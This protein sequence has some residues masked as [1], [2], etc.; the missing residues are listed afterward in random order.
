MSHYGMPGMAMQFPAGQG[1][2]PPVPFEIPK[3]LFRYGEQALWS[4]YMV[5]GAAGTASAIANAS[6]RLFA[7]QIGQVGSGFTNALSIAETNL[8]EAGRIPNAIA[9]DVYG[10]S[11]HVMLASAVADGGTLSQPINSTA[12]A[13][14]A[15]TRILLDVINNGVLS[16]DFTQTQVDIAPVSLCG[17]GGGMFGSIGVGDNDTSTI[18][19][20]QNN[21]P[22]SIWLYRKH[23]VALPGASTFAVLLRFGSRAAGLA[24]TD[25]S[26]AVKVSLLGAYRNVI[27]IG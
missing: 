19:G 17:S 25:F 8:K 9:F 4:T 22:G 6:Y 12:S 2:P 5:Q 3:N 13:A 7:T 26:F 18:V 24:A 1:G 27:E 20:H 10:I 11:T 16:W 23:P 21:G 14:T 15:G